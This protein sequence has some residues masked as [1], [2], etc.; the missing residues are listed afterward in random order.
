[1]YETSSIGVSH[2]LKM[3]QTWKGAKFQKFGLKDLSDVQTRLYKQLKTNLY[4][5]ELFPNREQ[6]LRQLDDLSQ[7][8]EFATDAFDLF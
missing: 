2:D 6:H 1:M 5:L 3:H 7:P 8:Y 4:P